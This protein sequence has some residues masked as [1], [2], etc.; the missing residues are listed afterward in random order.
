MSFECLLYN[1]Y[2]E[3]L[4]NILLNDSPLKIIRVN[5]LVEKVVIRQRTHILEKKL[6]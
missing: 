2:L 1:V 3:Q 6:Q 5:S 4:F